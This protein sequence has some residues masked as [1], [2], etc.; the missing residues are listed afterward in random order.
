[1]SGVLCC[2]I[3]SS[4]RSALFGSAA[5]G[6]SS[7]TRKRKRKLQSKHT[8]QEEYKMRFELFFK[9]LKDLRKVLDFYQKNNLCKVNIPCKAKLK[10]KLL[11]D[12]ISTTMSQRNF[13]LTPHFSIAYEFDRTKERTMKK[14]Y[15]F[16]ERL[17]VWKRFYSCLVLR[18]EKD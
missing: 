15:T 1:M 14:L 4:S 16:M 11:L 7:K 18:N 2:F 6:F 12:S 17:M 8:Q 9:D 13:R 10:R 3:H 5:H